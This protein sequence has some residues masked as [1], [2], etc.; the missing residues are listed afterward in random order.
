M[1]DIETALHPACGASTISESPRKNWLMK[2]NCSLSTCQIGWFIPLVVIPPVRNRLVFCL[3]TRVT[4][5]A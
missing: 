1:H 2:R 5:V 3:A 4:G